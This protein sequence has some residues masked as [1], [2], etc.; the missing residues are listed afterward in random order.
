MAT[1]FRLD[2][3]LRTEGSVSRALADAAEAGWLARHPEGTVVRRDVGLSPLPAEAWP[4]AFGQAQL[5]EAERSDAG[6]EAIALAATLA[7]EIINADAYLFAVP[8]Y[9]YGISQ[10]VKAWWDLAVADPR[11]S[12]YVEAP[13]AGKAGILVMA[14]GGGYSEGTPK[15][16]WDYASPWLR[17]MFGEVWG[18]DLEVVTAE[19]TLASVNPAMAELVGLAE[20]SQ[21]AALKEADAH[22]RTHAARLHAAA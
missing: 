8:L 12:A 6:R 5:P 22:G 10:Y 4:L 11:L 20:E 14:L 15:H 3:S 13:L 2:A 21:R 16:G 19:L 17:R 7:D 1:L 9:N 18:L